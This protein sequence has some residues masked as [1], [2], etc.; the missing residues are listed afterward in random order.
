MPHRDKNETHL[1]SQVDPGDLASPSLSAQLDEQ[2]QGGQNS[3]GSWNRR[4]KEHQTNLRDLWH[5]IKF[6]AGKGAWSV[7]DQGTG[8]VLAQ[9]D[10][11]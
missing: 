11:K 5:Q 2:L 7:G 4:R 1:R 3:S 8:A 6:D 10:R 9:G